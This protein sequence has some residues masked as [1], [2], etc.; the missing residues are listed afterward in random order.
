MLG[1]LRHCKF[2]ITDSGGLQKEAFFFK[3]PCVVLRE[4]TEWIELVEHG[5][6]VLAGANY[7]HILDAV[8]T[9]E[10]GEYDFSLRLYGD[11]EAGKKI[12]EALVKS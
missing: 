8:K 5:S 7:N 11:G 2:V 3:K 12:V 6:N 1:F 10:S 4:E 9:V